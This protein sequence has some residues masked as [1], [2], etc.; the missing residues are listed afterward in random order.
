MVS[1]R[2]PAGGHRLRRRVDIDVNVL[3]RG[4]PL[5]EQELRDDQI[6]PVSS[7]GVP[8]KMMRSFSSREK[9]S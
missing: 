8:M 6:R 5:Q 4:P 7:M 9:M 1:Y 3:L 2:S